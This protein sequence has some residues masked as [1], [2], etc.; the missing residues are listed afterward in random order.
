MMAR[1]MTARARNEDGVT[2]VEL[3]VVLMLMSIIAVIIFGFLYSVMNVSSRATNDS[4]SEKAISL[5]LR[6]VT[7][8]LRG[9]TSIATVYPATT[10][11]T[12][13][14]YPTGYTNCLSVTVLRPIPGQLTCPKTVFTYGLKSDGILREDRTDYAFVG[15]VCA[16]TTNYTGRKLLSNIVNGSQPLFTYFDRFGNQLDPAASGQ[17]ALPFTDAVTIRVTLNVRYQTGTPLLSYT[18]DFALRNNR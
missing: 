13:G 11:C 15:G 16:V 10:S 12:A 5:A 4:E 1:R 2:L 9:T 14:S 8:N 7:E 18:S 3:A 6:P 17:T